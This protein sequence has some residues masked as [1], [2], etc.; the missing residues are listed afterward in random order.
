MN[1]L[2]LY[3]KN[4]YNG[5]N[6]LDKLKSANGQGGSFIW[7]FVYGPACVMDWIIQNILM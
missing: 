1:I 2:S 6:I 3:L 5:F 7:L 4:I